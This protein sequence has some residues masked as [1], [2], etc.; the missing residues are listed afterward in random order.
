MQIADQVVD[1][2]L[3]SGLVEV[4]VS[5]RHVH[6]SQEDVEKLFGKGAEL[7]FKRPLSQP[8]QFLSEERVSIKGSKGKMERVAVLGPVRK[9]TQV[10]ISIS[11]TIALGV[12][13]PVRESGKLDG[14]G[15]ITIEGPCGTLEDV[16]AAIV[17]HNHIH[18]PVDVA[19][20]L[21]LK[22]GERVS[23]QILTERPVT[24]EDV[25][26][27]VSDK[28]RFK[29]HIDFDEANAAMVKG[30]TLGRIIKR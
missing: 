28:F 6:L 2:I 12:T 10:E 14:A 17:A 16:P 29:M 22:D 24:F 26:I 20:R 11:D 4:E 27:R 1:S 18:V 5:A 13:A 15:A 30:F 19:A 23:T 9:A 3:N 8:G 7:H 25:V 21:G